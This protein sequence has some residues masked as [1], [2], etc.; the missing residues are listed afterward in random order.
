MAAD[1]KLPKSSPK[2]DPFSA[3]ERDAILAA[4]TAHPHHYHYYSFVSFLFLTGCR[5]G[6]AIALQWQHI[7]PDFSYITFA[8]SYSCSLKVR[9]TTKTGVVRK[10][11]I[12]ADLWSLLVAIKLTNARPEDLVFSS[13]TGLPIN[14]SKFTNQVWRGCK[15]GQKTYKG[16]LPALV[17]SGAVASYRCP[18]NANARPT[19]ITMML[20]ARVTI[21]QVAKLV[22]NSPEIVL[23]HYAGSG[24]S[25]VP[26][27]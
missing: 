24:L 23:R 14:N 10:F 15:V 3:T 5:T 9:K 27:I 16:I 8:E 2:I 25:E 19:F 26:R 18:Y 12:N 11:P 1:V 22:G 7:R 20:E 21:P 13:P 6:E 4:F 17:A